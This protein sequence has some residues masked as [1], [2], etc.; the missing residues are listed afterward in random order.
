MKLTSVAA[1]VASQALSTSVFAVATPGFFG[2]TDYYYVSNA[3]DDGA[4]ILTIDNGQAA[5]WV[6]GQATVPLPFFN[7]FTTH[8]AGNGSRLTGINNSNTSFLFDLPS[9]PLQAIPSAPGSQ[10]LDSRSWAIS[11]NGNVVVGRDGSVG[12]W[13]WTP[14]NG[15]QLLTPGN[16]SSTA[17]GVS[18]DGV[19]TVG[20]TGSQPFVHTD[21]G[22]L[23]VIPRPAGATAAEFRGVSGDGTVA[24]G[25]ATFSATSHP[26]ILWSQ[27][28]GY[29]VLPTLPDLPISGDQVFQAFSATQDGSIVVGGQSSHRAWIWDAA[30]GTRDLHDVLVND[31]GYDLTGWTLENA[32]SISPDGTIITGSGGYFNGSGTAERCWVAVIPAPGGALSLMLA[33]GLARTRRRSR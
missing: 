33:A 23:Q 11:A 4:V 15:T 20:T 28:T 14:Q 19:T 17:Y 8:I 7:G 2:R 16:G 31:F 12:A 13:K 1:V 32:F 3:A 27:A 26:A 18:R 5:R 9:G 25:A 30:H 6:P 22:G 24:V 29:Q 10:V 21:A